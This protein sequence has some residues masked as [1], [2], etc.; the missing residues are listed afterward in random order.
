MKVRY[1]TILLVSILSV[2]SQ[3][4]CKNN[5][6]VG[7]S[8]PVTVTLSGTVVSSNSATPIEG[9]TVILSY[10]STKDSVTTGSNGSFQF[11]LDMTDT[12]GMNVTL[13]V[14]E[15]GY[16]RYS[17]TFNVKS[18]QSFQVSL[19]IN[20]LDYAILNGAVR[21]KASTW[22]LTGASV[23]VSLPGA[24]SSSISY[25]S[26]FKSHV[27]SLS[28]FIID[29][30]TSG[31]L[32]KFS[33]IIPFP[34]YL[35][36]VSAT[37][38]VA[39]AGFVTQQII[40]TFTKGTTDSVVVLLPQDTSQSVA[41][42][43][44][45]VTD[46]HSLLPITNVSVILTSTLMKDTIKTLSDGSYSFDFD[47][48]G[49][50]SSVSGTLLFQ[51]S[52]YDDTTLS[53][54]V[55]AGKTLTENVALS[56]K[57]TVVGGDSSTARGIA[58]SISLVSVSSQEISIHGV[59]RNETSVLVWQVLDS[60]G[61]PVDINH[62]DT[63]TFVPTGPAVSGSDPAYVTPTSGITDGS[64]QISTTVNSG[65]V[66]GTIQLLAELTLQNGK[67]VQSSPVLITVDGGLPDQKHFELNSNL[68][69]ASNFAGYDWSEITQGFTVQAA[70]TFANPVAP[71]TAIY[72]TTTSGEITAAGQTD[73]AGHA[74]AT[75]YSGSPLPYEPPVTLSAFLLRRFSVQVDT[76]YFGNGKGYAFVSAHTQGA[77][78][79]IVADSDVI[80]IS[81]WGTVSIVDTNASDTIHANGAIEFLVYIRDENG[82]PLESAT[83]VAATA[84]VPTPPPTDLGTAW[85]PIVGGDLVSSSGGPIT[86]GDALTRDQMQNGLPLTYGRT[87][88]Y[89]TFTP[90]LTQG[91]APPVTNFFLQ[92][93]VQGRNTGN[94][95][96][97]VSKTVVVVP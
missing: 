38:T 84:T 15:T 69:H 57:A 43:V 50:S 88:F 41:H 93:T 82:N 83:T 59:G 90:T 80:C 18:N 30:T 54:S 31:A 35:D 34:D 81:G 23:V 11:T 2:C 85:S 94:A 33:L 78:G 46:S 20:P 6:I 12:S 7:T 14:Y 68:P 52:G 62:R 58:R 95:L 42:L 45:Q 56:A 29:S 49:A 37:M 32:G 74:N 26:Y 8:A 19:N 16:I 75:L 53:F 22:P 87:W 44:G 64:G 79:T 71:S 39:K 48:P 61:F 86:F 24:S 13:T 51:L 28:S 77:N 70:D 5:S 97:A 21:D 67:R 66:A 72:F 55:D 27:K 40:R 73:A 47:L 25:L 3:W 60:L 65:T 4:S 63:V 10:G 91:S 76:S 17:N 89:V 1:G 92:I 96:I 36:T 9:A